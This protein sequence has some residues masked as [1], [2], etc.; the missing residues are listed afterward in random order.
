M[1]LDE[2]RPIMA[3]AAD[4]FGLLGAIRPYAA[5]GYVARLIRGSYV[6]EFVRSTPQDAARAAVYRL[7]Q[8]LGLEP[9]VF[10]TD[11]D[12]A[13]ERRHRQ[14]D[15]LSEAYAALGGDWRAA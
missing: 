14:L 10:A 2:V 12:A 13:H 1:T 8:E 5:G 6:T 11:S 3:R 9:G 15:A 4:A 7:K